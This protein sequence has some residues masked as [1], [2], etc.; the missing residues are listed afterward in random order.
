LFIPD[1]DPDFLPITD[2][3]VKKAPDPG[4]GTLN[5]SYQKS[6]EAVAHWKKSNMTRS[7]PWVNF[8]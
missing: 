2:P 7:W 5:G 1:T 8:N 4:S 3:G 6:C